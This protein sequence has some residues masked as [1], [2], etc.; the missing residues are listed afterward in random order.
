[1]ACTNRVADSVRAM[2][3]GAGLLFVSAASG[4]AQEGPDE[5]V[6]GEGKSDFSWHCSACHGDSAKGDGPMAKMLIKP[7]ADL[8]AIA[9]AHGGTFPFWRVYRVIAGKSPVPGH[10][11]FQMPDFWRRFSGDEKEW[12]FLPPHVRVLELTHYVESLQEK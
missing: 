2:L 8:T 1:M 6:I 10:E 9:K 3:L 4:L 7:P 12:G 11:T 5:Q